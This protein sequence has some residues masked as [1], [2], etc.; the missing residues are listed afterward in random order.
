MLMLASNAAPS[1]YL[2]LSSEYA[3]CQNIIIVQT[4]KLMV[5]GPALKFAMFSFS[6]PFLR[7]NFFLGYSFVSN[8]YSKWTACRSFKWFCCYFAGVNKIWNNTWKVKACK[9]DTYHCSKCNISRARCISR[10]QSNG[11]GADIKT[12]PRG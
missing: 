12:V 4:T 11:K 7:L 10:F 5:T 8:S 9:C 2:N 1:P 6:V 3:Y